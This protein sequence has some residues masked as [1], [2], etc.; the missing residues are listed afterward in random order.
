MILYDWSMFLMIIW[1][2]FKSVLTQWS[3][4]RC[5]FHLYLIYFR[6][7]QSKFSI[8][9]HKWTEP[10]VK[11]FLNDFM[12][13]ERKD[14]ICH[15]RWSVKITTPS[16]SK[17]KKK[18]VKIIATYVCNVCTMTNLKSVFCVQNL[19]K[20][21]RFLVP[22]QFSSLQQKWYSFLENTNSLVR[23]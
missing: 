10:I 4:N 14:I 5:S 12:G 7:L 15:R 9:F 16:C 6:K 1:M 3:L 22:K 11:I 21:S 23:I 17:W 20:S 8:F 18:R 13:D 19:Q 2:V